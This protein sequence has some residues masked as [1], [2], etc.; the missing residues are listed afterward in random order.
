M[1]ALPHLFRASEFTGAAEPLIDGAP[2]PAPA[3]AKPFARGE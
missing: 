1:T 3:N 2:L